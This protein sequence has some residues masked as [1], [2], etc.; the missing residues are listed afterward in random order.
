MGDHEENSDEDASLAATRELEEE[1]GYRA[2]SMTDCGEFYSSPGMVSE[3]FALF[4]AEGL[5]KVGEGGGVEGEKHHSIPGGT[6]IAENT[7]IQ[8]KRESGVCN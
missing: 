5:N 2:Q 6:I 1:T 3:S 8:Q 7:F 4:K